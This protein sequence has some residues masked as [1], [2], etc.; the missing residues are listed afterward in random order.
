MIHLFPEDTQA[1]LQSIVVEC[2]NRL[3]TWF[4]KSDEFSQF[5]VY[6]GYP[7]L[8]EAA[9]PKIDR[10]SYRQ[11]ALAGRYFAYATF[12]FDRLMDD[13]PEWMTTR[14]LRG[15][16]VL[17]EG[18][19][20]LYDL[21]PSD[22]SFW[23]RFHEL[24]R[25]YARACDDEA[26]IAGGHL[27]WSTFTPERA[28]EIAVG[29]TALAQ[30]TIH[31]LGCLE[32]TKGP[33]LELL[34]RSIR[35][36]YM[37]R[38]IWDDVCDWKEDLRRHAP[39]LLL[40][41]LLPDGPAQS[42]DASDAGRLARSLYYDG[43]LQEVM[44]IA[45]GYLDQALACCEPW[46][47]LL[48]C[49]VLQK[50]K[51]DCLNLQADVD[52]IVRSN[53]ERL[54]RH[55]DLDLKVASGGTPWSH[56]AGIA[57][58]GI[59]REWRNGFGEAR[60]I[61]HLANRDGFTAETEFHHGDIFQRA[62]IVDALCDLRD[63]LPELAGDQVRLLLEE[64]SQYLV[65]SR[66]RDE[67]GGWK[68]FPTVPELA[69]DADDLAQVMQAL[70]R[71]GHPVELANLVE[72][73]LGILVE[74]RAL[75]DGSYETWIVPNPPRTQLQCRQAAFNEGKWGVGPDIE[76][77]ANLLFALQ[78]Y[79]STRFQD[80]IRRG[81]DWLLQR[82]SVDGSWPCRWYVGPFYGTYVS[83]RLLER[84]APDAPGL[85]KGKQFV[86]S[87][88]GADKGWG[89][90]R[91]SDPLSTALALLILGM[92]EVEGE[93]RDRADA[94]QAYLMKSRQAGGSWAASPFITP[95]MGE[96]YVSRTLAEAYVAKA[97][98]LWASKVSKVSLEMAHG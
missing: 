97:C 43:H 35:F 92:G 82:Q 22:S 4:S 13:Q 42:P 26:N 90:H 75:E 23:P 85:A 73:P 34:L 32:R 38:Q 70:M 61:M 63:N 19:R 76:V 20:V 62:I 56:L 60:H 79:D 9:F 15:Q 1:E 50:V 16:L 71:S 91:Q 2:A 3:G 94:A 31:G 83:M 37:G 98:A 51:A 33:E 87:S 39:S 21:F 58:Q 52:R 6:D 25:E 64:E 67:P 69:P 17:A 57:L 80:R 12:L 78:L 53:L 14:V 5:T 68:Y 28:M 93:D 55:Q 65:E 48:W 8:F 49:H 36:Y 44:G 27:P 10:R 47:K 84:V 7:Y 41:R 18:Y 89:H 59:L 66:E 96:N 29:K 74:E 88:Q 72:Q 30:A 45:V 24:L 54:Q 86:R 11:L 81:A 46:P 40:A 77:V 95:R